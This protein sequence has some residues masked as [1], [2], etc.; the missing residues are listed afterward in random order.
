MYQEIESI[1]EENHNQNIEIALLKEIITKDLYDDAH[2]DDH[3]SNKRPARLLPSRILHGD[4]KNNKSHVN[5]FYGP[6]TNCS[7][8]SKLGYTLNGFYLVK[9]PIIT[10]A[11]TAEIETIHC[12]FRQPK[13][14]NASL[15]ESRVG[16]LSTS[17]PSTTENIRSNKTNSGV[18]FY[19][20]RLLEIKVAK[21][22][23]FT[24]DVMSF[25]FGGGFNGSSGVFKAPKSG[26][27][28]F[29]FKG[30]ISWVLNY[31]KKGMPTIVTYI[32]DFILST[33]NF[34]LYSSSGHINSSF[35]MRNIDN[36]EPMNVIFQTTVLLKLGDRFNFKPKMECTVKTES[37]NSFSG[38]LL[39]EL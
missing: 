3:S 17:H 12:S 29:Y 33:H 25:N 20:R 19:A 22:S 9:S 15:L 6:P 28:Q 10:N 1:K 34:P 38:S 36:R 26:V 27:Y 4:R 35:Y 23:P 21:D 5:I 2:G 18:H 37:A 16:I 31:T 13:N 8:L 11:S 7:D 14:F 39:E 24:F 30:W 32:N